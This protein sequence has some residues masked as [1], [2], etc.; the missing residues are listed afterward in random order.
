MKF[1]VVMAR[2]G[3]QRLPGKNRMVLAGKPLFE[4]TLRAALD[5]GCFDSVWISSDDEDIL[6]AAAAV[7][8]V[9]LDRRPEA[10]AG[11]GVPGGDV[12]RHMIALVRATD[13]AYGTFCMLQPTSPFR[14]AR[15]IRRAMELLDEPG[16][17]FVVGVREFAT[18]PHFA[19]S[20]EDGLTPVREGCLTRI[21]RTQDVPA[22]CHPAGG[23]YAGSVD[24]FLRQGHFYGPNTMP[25]D[26]GLVA[27]MDINTMEDF[28]LCEILAAGL[29]SGEGA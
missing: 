16:C 21:T 23:L 10:L 18:P 22:Y 12:L 7:P 5:A 28:R 8:G 13:P 29:D 19:L 27:A 9:S 3:S 24:A 4:W 25:L 6:A 14:R 2:K 17:E 1:A 15:D 20:R 11:P 26:M